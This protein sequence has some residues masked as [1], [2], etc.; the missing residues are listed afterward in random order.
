MQNPLRSLYSLLKG[1]EVLPENPEPLYIVFLES[2]TRAITQPL[3]L[4]KIRRSVEFGHFEEEVL[5]NA[6]LI[7]FPSIGDYICL[8][9]IEREVQRDQSK[10]YLGYDESRLFKKK[11][12][13]N[14][15]QWTPK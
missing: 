8:A 14:L 5:Q 15:W 1:E 6:I 7:P 9:D 11:G 3:T 2:K 12:V 10:A 4:N 13:N